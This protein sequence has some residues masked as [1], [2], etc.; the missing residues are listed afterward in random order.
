MPTGIGGHGGPPYVTKIESKIT[1]H[2][3]RRP[4][5]WKWPGLLAQPVLHHSTTPILQYSITRIP[6]PDK[7]ELKIED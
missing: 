4:G 7:P 1:F 5:R 3:R 6:D 2:N